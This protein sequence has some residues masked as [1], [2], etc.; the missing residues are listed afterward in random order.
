MFR[1]KLKK[2]PYLELRHQRNTDVIFDLF[3]PNLKNNMSNLLKQRL[4]DIIETL[5]PTS[6]N[7]SLKLVELFAD[8]QAETPRKGWL[9]VVEETG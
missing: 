4:Y 7:G 1:R 3:C 2:S 6:L 9:Q 8:E 5:L